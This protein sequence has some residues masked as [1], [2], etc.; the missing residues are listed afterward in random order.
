MNDMVFDPDFFQKLNTLKMNLHMHLSQGMSGVRKSSAKGSSV[1]FSDYREYIPGDDIRR[2]DWNAYGRTDKFYIKQFMEEQEGLF[3]IF[4]DTSGSM[5]FGDKP[6]SRMALQIAAAL[7]YIVL[8]NLDRVYVNQ[9]RE[10]SLQRGKGVTGMAAFPHI[11]EDLSAIT[12]EGGTTLSNSIRKRPLA[13]GGVSFVISDFL[14]AKGIADAV[15]YLAYRKQTVCLVQI[16]AREEL[17]ADYEGTLNFEDLETKEK[18]KITLSNAAIRQYQERLSNL[19]KELEALAR[20]YGASY[21]CVPSDAPL[22]EVMLQG[23]SGILAGK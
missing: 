1:E 22:T 10:N 4:V 2:I 5:A 9:L 18:V 12:F 11:L 15:R 13:V 23:F 14:D 16:L 21:V 8:G 20:Q 7:A 6:K 19:R 17:E 3:H